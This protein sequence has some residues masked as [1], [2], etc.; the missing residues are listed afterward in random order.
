MSF[1][2]LLRTLGESLHANDE[3]RAYL[4]LD[5]MLRE[6]LER[7]FILAAGCE[8]FPIVIESARLSAHQLPCLVR[9]RP[10]SVQVLRAS[11]MAA[12]EE[13]G[14]ADI[15]NDEGFAVG[16]WL[17][18]AA[19]PEAI[20]K[21]LARCMTPVGMP[22]G[23]RYLRLA[24]RRVFELVWSV[25]DEAQRREWFGPISQWWTLDRRNELVAHAVPQPADWQLNYK[26][27]PP[28]NGRVCVTA[29]LFS[30]CCGAGNVFSRCC[31]LTTCGR[32]WM[33]L[34]QPI[35]RVSSG[36]RHRGP[37]QPTSCRFIRVFASIRV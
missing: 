9:L 35:A 34:R 26:K 13:Q 1:D 5:P 18:S 29:S 31:L 28:S 30:S 12:L 22:A 14:D 17:R 3:E 27:L 2:S 11:L 23:T 6:P 33:R 8:V 4:L 16:G 25:L 10:A 32:Q 7:D 36:C 20:V 21:H 15:E 24:D 37:W 19:A